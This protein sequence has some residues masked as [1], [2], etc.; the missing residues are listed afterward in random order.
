MLLFCSRLVLLT[1]FIYFLAI[2]YIQKNLKLYELEND[3]TKLSMHAQANFCRN[4]LATAL[5]RGPYQVDV[6]LGGY[7]EKTGASLYFMD[8][9]AALCK[10]KYSAQGYASNFCLSTMDRDYLDNCN[11][12]DALKI[13]K[14]CIHELHTRFLLSQPNFIIKV[15]DKD[16]VTVEEFGSDPADT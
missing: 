2:R 3:G 9:L 1:T 6:L 5:R 7:D 8:H 14:K 15:I 10:V 4:E 13:I 16:G 11:K 12:E